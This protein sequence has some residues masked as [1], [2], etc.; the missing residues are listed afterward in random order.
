MLCCVKNKEQEKWKEKKQL[1]GYCLRSGERWWWPGRKGGRASGER[2]GYTC[3]A[4]AGGKL[5]GPGGVC[6]VESERRDRSGTTPILL[7]L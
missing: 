5:S 6:D 4:P 7:V 2:E 1:G 3:E